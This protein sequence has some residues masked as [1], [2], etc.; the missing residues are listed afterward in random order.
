MEH[1]WVFPAV[2]NRFV[3]AVAQRRTANDVG[4]ITRRCG[5]LATITVA[6]YSIISRHIACKCL[7]NVY[8]FLAHV[9]CTIFND[10]P[11]FTWTTAECQNS[12]NPCSAT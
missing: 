9:P 7:L 6:A 4:K 2:I 10:G 5:L 1:V 3:A 8:K 11:I 12:R